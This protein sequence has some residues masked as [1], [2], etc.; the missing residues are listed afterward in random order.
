MARLM[1]TV[2]GGGRAAGSGAPVWGAAT[3][4][5]LEGRG[6]GWREGA[7]GL[8]RYPLFGGVEGFGHEGATLGSRAKLLV[9]P[10]MGLG[11]FIAANSDTG[12]RLVRRLPGAIVARFGPAGPPPSPAVSAD[13][14]RYEGLYLSTRRAYHGLEGFVD[15]LTRLYRVRGDGRGGLVVG[16]RHAR[17]FAPTSTPD[18]FVAAEGG[19][20][21]LR[22]LP[23]R[24]GRAATFED[25]GGFGA[26]DRVGWLHWPLVLAGVAAAAL[27]A[28]LLALAGPFVRHARDERQ[29]PAQ[30][31]AVL[32]QNGAAALWLAATVAFTAFAAR[33]VDP[34]RLYT[35]WPD[36][37]LKVASW[38]GL[39]A[40]LLSLAQL[41]QVGGV[42][43][44]GRRVQGWHGW[45]KLRHSLTVFRVPRLR[46]GAGELGRAGAVVGLRARPRAWT[47]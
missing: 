8:M 35:E 16:G 19:A 25:P 38:L 21:R 24:S 42:W 28:A 31:R 30:G 3:A 41:V 37:W 44:E 5:A 15:R 1:L 11:V 14:H 13:P 23:G 36:P 47:P 4:Q 12:E 26:A 39:A 20:A 6:G 22:F 40:A 33:A 34:V 32:L 7:G 10:A 46:R 43:N 27:L 29:T 17:L 9:V 18:V 2:L 45:R